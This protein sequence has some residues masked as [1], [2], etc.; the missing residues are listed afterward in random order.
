MSGNH[1]VHRHSLPSFCRAAT[2]PLTFPHAGG[3]R[4]RFAGIFEPAIHRMPPPQIR[5]NV[6]DRHGPLPYL[7]TTLATALVK[8]VHGR[9]RSSIGEGRGTSHV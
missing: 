6:A 4:S 1:S 2:R 8:R 3:T 5:D 9:G 7:R